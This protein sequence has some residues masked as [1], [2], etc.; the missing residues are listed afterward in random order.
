MGQRPKSKSPLI[1]GDGDAGESGG[2]ETGRQR[3]RVNGNR[4]VGDLEQAH[5]PA[6][7]AV[8][9]GKHGGAEDAAELLE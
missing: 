3:L 9:A 4:G 5:Y 6:I 7:H 8:R 1:G 2:L